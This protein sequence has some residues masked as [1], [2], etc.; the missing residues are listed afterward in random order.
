M[1]IV[2]CRTLPSEGFLGGFQRAGDEGVV[3]RADA[4]I[5]GRTSRE[6]G[7]PPLSAV[8]SAGLAEAHPRGNPS[9]R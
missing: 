7:P 4:G 3:A 9:V 5:L 6:G 1:D 8:T 2:D